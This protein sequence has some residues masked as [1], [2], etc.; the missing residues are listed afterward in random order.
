MSSN[1]CLCA[2]CAGRG[3]TCCQRTEIYVTPGD[4]G[5][6]C[7]HT[8]HFDFYEFQAPANPAYADQSDDP[9]WRQH[10]FHAD[11]RRRVLKHRPSGD[12]VF[13]GAEGCR[14]PES[15]RPLVCRLYPY[16]YTAAGI[17]PEPDAAC[18]RDLLPPGRS[19]TEELRM[20]MGRALAW[21]HLL[22]EEIMSDGDDDWTDLRFAV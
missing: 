18:P 1:E 21:H 4:V 15:V 20:P 9:V 2:R 7:K 22:Y 6:I 8:G 16:T 13:L 17:D 11:G 3:K 10:V 12:C 19:V 5:R 14:L